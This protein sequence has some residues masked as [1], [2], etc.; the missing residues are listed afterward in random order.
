MQTKRFASAS[1]VR[2]AAC[3]AVFLACAAAF[4]FI[5][6]D[7]PPGD[8]QT[9]RDLQIERWLEGHLTPALVQAMQAV[10]LLHGPVALLLLGVVAAL[11]LL[12]RRRLR[13]VLALLLVL[14]GGMLLNVLLKHVF[15]R[16]RPVFEHPL[17][18]LQSYSFP[19]G[20][21]EGST[22]WYGLLVMGVWCA[23]E[24]RRVR[25]AAVCGA[26][27][28]VAAVSLSRMVLGA[29]YLSDVLGAVCV[30][31]GWLALCLWALQLRNRPR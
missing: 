7:L 30:G 17:V 6:E 23:T 24:D 31:M 28:M 12:Q 18:H 16:A 25:A 26:V 4:A 10:S 29:H 8:P 20:H 27:L 13:A 21:V 3:L 9:L 19:S 22:V 11:V 1:R 5:A 15:Q 14:P 2:A